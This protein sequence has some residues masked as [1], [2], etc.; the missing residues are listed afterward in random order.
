MASLR[1]TLFSALTGFLLVLLAPWAAAQAPAGNTP[2]RGYIDIPGP[3]AVVVPPFA[4]A[5]WAIDLQATGPTVGVDAVQV[6]IAPPAGTFTLLGFAQLGIERA[7]VAAIYGP[8]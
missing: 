7:D 4:L 2:L 3:G 1:I 8:A 5:G 6:W